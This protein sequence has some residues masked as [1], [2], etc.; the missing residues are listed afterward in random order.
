M[1]QEIWLKKFSPTDGKADPRIK[2]TQ[3]SSCVVDAFRESTLSTAF[4]SAAVNLLA[5]GCDKR[6]EQGSR[7]A[8]AEI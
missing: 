2:H 8:V 6:A 7:C 3:G 1:A 4:H 5:V